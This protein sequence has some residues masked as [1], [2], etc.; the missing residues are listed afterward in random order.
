M[1]SA[2]NSFPLK[3]DIHLLRRVWATQALNQLDI[4]LAKQLTQS[5]SHN[6]RAAGLRAIYYDAS[7]KKYKNLLPI[8]EEAVSDPSPHVRL[9][10]VSLL[11]QL[12]SPKTVAIALRA[13]EGVEVDD[14]L[15]L[16][17]GQYVES[18]VT[19]GLMR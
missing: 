18:I 16:P 6:A 10:G 3:D 12:D 14:F 1:L 13:L 9:W 4:G 8:A 17:Y 2:L 11:A 19:G 5:K 15:D 7:N